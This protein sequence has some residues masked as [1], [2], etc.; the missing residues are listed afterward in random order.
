MSA[1]KMTGGTK[2]SDQQIFELGQL[3]ADMFLIRNIISQGAGIRGRLLSQGEC[4]RIEE[5]GSV[6]NRVIGYLM[7][8]IDDHKMK[9]TSNN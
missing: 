6:A 9:S 5:I 7:R 3:Y 1:Q 4:E 2:M 8:M